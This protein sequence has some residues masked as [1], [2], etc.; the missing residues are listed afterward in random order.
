MKWISYKEIK[1][2][3]ANIDDEILILDAHGHYHIVWLVEKSKN[4]I[5]TPIIECQSCYEDDMH[6]GCDIGLH[7]EVA[8]WLVLKGPDND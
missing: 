1:P 6:P 5:L 4:K 2:T 3:K 8:Y 7:T